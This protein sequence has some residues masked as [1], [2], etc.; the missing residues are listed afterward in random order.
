MNN[1]ITE[2]LFNLVYSNLYAS[3]ETILVNALK[4]RF[5]GFRAEI[6]LQNLF[7][8]KKIDVLEGGF[9]VPL[10]D[11]K[12]TLN[13][14]VYFTAGSRPASYY[15]GL[16]SALDKGN[17]SK[18]IYMRYN[19]KVKID[20]W[21]LIKLKNSNMEFPVPDFTIYDFQGDDF[22][23]TGNDL[24]FLLNLFTPKKNHFTQKIT[25]TSRNS[26][27]IKNYLN[28]YSDDQLLNLYVS[29][30][31]FDGFIGLMHFKG[32]P[33]DI[34]L[35]REDNG[36][37]KFYEVKEKDLSKTHPVGFGIDVRRLQDCLKIA[38]D[39]EDV[40]YIYIVRQVNNQT[41]RNFVAWRYI[42]FTDFNIYTDRT[43]IKEG[44]AGMNT[45]SSGN[46]NPTLLTEEKYFGTLE[47]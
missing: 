41:D 29:R 5:I 3:T 45:L 44:G 6:E 43:K 19:S 26:Q 30:L 9:I 35:I 23:E 2:L 20:E 15:K 39:L 11:G 24:N 42:D 1:R 36:I 33:S 22:V 31:V 18:L 34:D 10:R 25:I 13:A 4:N 16:Y 28:E 38:E 14:P 7:N 17:F 47:D 8:K 46:D 12:K 21:K 40:K 37:Y 27:L 32:I